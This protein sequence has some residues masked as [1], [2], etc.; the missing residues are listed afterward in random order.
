MKIIRY[1]LFALGVMAP[2]LL[3]SAVASACP[4]C[5]GST[6]K[7]V[8]YTY[9]LSAI[10]LSIMPLVIIGSILGWL[11]WHKRRSHRDEQVQGDQRSD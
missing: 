9:Y 2:I 8:L 3:I 11:F 4:N 6:D 10:F 5:F 1:G 7:N